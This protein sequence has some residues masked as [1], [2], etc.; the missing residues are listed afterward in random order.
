M[1]EQTGFSYIYDVFFEILALEVT[2]EQCGETSNSLE[3]MRALAKERMDEEKSRDE[4]DRIAQRRKSI[5]CWCDLL[6]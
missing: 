6:T 2:G 1:V 5:E 4:K 3:E